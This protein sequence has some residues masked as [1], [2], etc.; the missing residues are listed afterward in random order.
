MIRVRK[1]KLSNHPV[2]GN[3]ELD[4]TDSSNQAVDT[5]II[6]GNNGIGKSSLVELLYQI[7]T[8]KYHDMPCYVDSIEV[9]VNAEIKTYKFYVENINEHDFLYVKDDLGFEAWIGSDKFAEVF[10]TSAIFSD[11][12][13]NFQSK[14]ITNVTSRNI[15]ES[16]ESRRSSS[17]LPTEINQ[18]IIDIQALDDA[19]VAR[20]VRSDPD[21]SFSSLQIPQRMPRFTNAF[22]LI[23][24]DLR[25]DR[26]E[27]RDGHKEILFKKNGHDV[28]V[29]QL[30]SGEKQIV[31][32]GCFMMK[33]S[34]ALRGS[35][36][37]ID[38]PEISL[39]PSWQEKILHFY[40]SLFQDE[41]G[42]QTSQFFCVTHSPFIIHDEKRYNDKVI[43]LARNES[44][45][46]VAQVNPEFYGPGTVQAVKDAFSVSWFVSETPTVYLEGPTDEQYFNKALS[47]AHTTNYLRFKW[48]GKKSPDG[49][50]AFTGAPSLNK[51][52][53]YLDANP[54]SVFTAF[55]Y[56]CDQKIAE[57]LRNNVLRTKMET[58]KSR[59][60]FKKGIENALVLDDDFDTSAFYRE[61]QTFGDYGDKK[62]ISEFQKQSFC[63]H[64]CSL[65]EGELKPILTHLIDAIER[66]DKQIT[67][68]KEQ[69]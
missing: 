1:I 46:V 58:Y 38:E 15:D 28:R 59:K 68:A 27:N 7:V 22:D 48:I 52:A 69:K 66:I 51:A 29:D 32:R 42:R 33:D 54:P 19:D 12:D 56:D 4:F 57:C 16:V 62:V 9:E 10:P 67:I 2:L 31:Y 61:K 13:I 35:F 17:D 40:K 53:A 26:V 18:L 63:D 41:E 34:N 44:G 60:N 43:V 49:S 6:A 20:A 45:D 50:C 3:L 55:L 14:Q 21:A 47:F 36:V 11:V 5:V 23:F 24:D 65:P 64:I 8:R 39:H 30:S 25:Y 37:F